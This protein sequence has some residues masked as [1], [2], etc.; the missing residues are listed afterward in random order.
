MSGDSEASQ[1][2]GLFSETGRG[3]GIAYAYLN[4]RERTVAEM[5]SR[6]QKAE[7]DEREINDVIEELLQ[8][9]YLDDARYARVFTEDRRNLDR[10]G[11]DRIIR[12]LRERGV[13][14][15]VIAAALAAAPEHDELAQARELLER[16]LPNG[17]REP[18]DRDKA[19]AMLVRK[20][21]SSELAADAVRAWAGSGGYG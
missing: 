3:F 7:I 6:L 1:N 19:F 20:G 5:T 9:G 14:R 13:D 11:N 16:R 17:P 8:L 18:R 2:E 10:W 15:D 4:R 12:G 21:Y